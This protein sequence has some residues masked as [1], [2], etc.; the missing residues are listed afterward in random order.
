MLRD[1]WT[2]FALEGDGSSC[3][4]VSPFRAHGFCFGPGYVYIIKL[5]YTLDE[6]HIVRTNIVIDDKLIADAQ[7]V[8]GIKTKKGVVEEGLRLLVRI[9]KQGVVRK[10]R[11]KLQWDDDLDAMRRDKGR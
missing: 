3:Q 2:V 11:G 8:T 9:R 7:K 6:R 4:V 1:N 10:W 5:L